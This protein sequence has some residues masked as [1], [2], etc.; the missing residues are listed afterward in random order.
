MNKAMA[1]LKDSPF[2]IDDIP[3]LTV[4]TFK[5]KA[6]ELIAD[7][8]VKLIF[9]D[10]LQL[11]RDPQEYI[12]KRVDEIVY[13]V[14]TLEDTTKELDIPL[15][16]LLQMYRI[17]RAHTGSHNKPQLRDLCKSSSIEGHADLI[18]LISGCWITLSFL[19]T[20][21]PRLREV[22]LF[23]TRTNVNR[24]PRCHLHP[25]DTCRTGGFFSL[26]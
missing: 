20:T 16:V 10:Y 7:K 19:K 23:K 26:A 1:A 12:G 2:Y 11:M 8:G 18:F 5:N 3:S 15:I 13:I 24:I 17:L 9:I 14:R 21:P 6:K 25:N 22:L 4:D